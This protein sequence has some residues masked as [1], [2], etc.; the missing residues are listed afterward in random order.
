MRRVFSDADGELLIVPERG[1]LLLRTEF[2]LLHVEPGHI[3]LIPRGVRFRVELLDQTARGYVCENY[4]APFRVPDLGPIG[5]NGLANAR[6][7]RAPV[8]AYEDVEG[9]VERAVAD[10]GRAADRRAPAGAVA[11]G[12]RPPDLRRRDVRRR[13]AAAGHLP[14]PRAAHGPDPPAVPQAG[15]R[16]AQ[17]GPGPDRPPRRAAGCGGLPRR[18][19]GLVPCR[20]PGPRRTARRAA[21]RRPG[22]LAA[23]CGAGPPHAVAA[24]ATPRT[25]RCTAPTT[26]TPG[27]RWT[28]APARRST[29]G[30]RPGSSPCA[31][32]PGR[33]ATSVWRSPATAA[34]TRSSSPRSASSNTPWAR[35]SPATTSARPRRLNRRRDSASY[36]RARSPRRGTG[37]PVFVSARAGQ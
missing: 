3:A 15:R 1:G 36:G 34:R 26:A 16:R 9:P 12:G 33:T 8:A 25:G 4:G 6:D 37:P 28:P 27:R 2:G 11:G 22:H 13:P 19:P 23:R 24:T 21:H 5:A 32:R 7:F 29:G 31:A 17:S 35:A 10:P 30:T 18:R 20:R 14:L